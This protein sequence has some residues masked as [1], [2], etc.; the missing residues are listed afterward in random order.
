MV[1][2]KTTEK[3]SET[4][5]YNCIFLR[6]IAREDFITYSRVVQLCSSLGPIR[7][8]G[9]TVKVVLTLCLTGGVGAN[10]V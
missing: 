9:L 1:L 5:D 3:V 8:D 6:L 7:P 2:Q 4:S 10:N